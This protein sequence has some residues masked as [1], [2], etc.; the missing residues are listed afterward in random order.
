MSA[1]S[2]DADINNLSSYEIDGG[3]GFDDIHI[4]LSDVLFAQLDQGN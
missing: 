1:Y 3:D 4:D 2:Q